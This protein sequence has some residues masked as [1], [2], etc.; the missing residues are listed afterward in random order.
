MI[1]RRIA[2]LT[3]FIPP[4]QEKREALV[5]DHVLKLVENLHQR[6]ERLEQKA[7]LQSGEAKALA[8][9]LSQ[10]QTE[11]RSNLELHKD[12]LAKVIIKT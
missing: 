11:E 12:L 2:G 5:R 8:V 4:P 10:I 9:L 3:E 6:I 1:V 7:G